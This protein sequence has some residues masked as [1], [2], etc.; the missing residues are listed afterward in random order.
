MDEKKSR[1]IQNLISVI[2][3]VLVAVVALFLFIAS[4]NQKLTGTVFNVIIAVFLSYYWLLLD[5]IEPLL[6]K[7]FK[8]ITKKRKT[9]YVKYLVVD[10]IGYV[11]LAV[12]I[13]LVGGKY[14]DRALAGAAIYVACI[15]LKKR[16]REEFLGKSHYKKSEQSDEKQLPDEEEKGR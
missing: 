7:Q 9:A 6:L 11:G 5:V 4:K 14:T 3:L 15:S 8:D 16:L 2:S 12:F 1:K 10:A 13:F